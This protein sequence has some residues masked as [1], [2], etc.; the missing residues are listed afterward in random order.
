VQGLPFTCIKAIVIVLC[1]DA[2]TPTRVGKTIADV[3][4]V[5]LECAACIGE[6]RILTHSTGRRSDSRA[7]VDREAA[8]M[9]TM[10]H[11]R[12]EL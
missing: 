10:F 12:Y 2:A 7:K 4:A 11:A 9:A 3:T 6:E 5:S 1:M 8:V